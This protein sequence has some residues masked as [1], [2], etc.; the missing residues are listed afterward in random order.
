MPAA[1]DALHS[2]LSCIALDAIYLS[3][4]ALS[5]DLD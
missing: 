2:R 4:V 5:E 3:T 1:I